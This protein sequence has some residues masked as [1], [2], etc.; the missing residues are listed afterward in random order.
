[1]R[2]CLNSL[3]GLEGLEVGENDPGRKPWWWGAHQYT[4]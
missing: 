2:L 4:L 3:I 1:L